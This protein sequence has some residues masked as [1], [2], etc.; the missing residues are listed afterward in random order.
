M[1]LGMSGGLPKGTQEEEH[2]DVNYYVEQERYFDDAYHATRS[3]APSPASRSVFSPPPPYSAVPGT[4]VDTP[5]PSSANEESSCSSDDF[6]SSD[7]DFNSWGHGPGPPPGSSS[8]TS[9]LLPHGHLLYTF[10]L[11]LD[12]GTNTPPASPQTPGTPH[13][14]P[15]PPANGPGTLSAASSPSP[16][17]PVMDPRVGG[18]PEDEVAPL[19]LGP[20]P[21]R[22]RSKSCRLLLLRT[23]IGI[24]STHNTNS[25]NSVP[26]AAPLS[27]KRRAVL[28]ERR[29]T[30]TVPIRPATVRTTWTCPLCRGNK[31]PITFARRVAYL[32]HLKIAHGMSW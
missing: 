22:L 21:G 8:S 10:A 3:Q 18:Q 12:I 5:H 1:A 20:S 23:S 28:T 31:P 15:H 30:A 26:A 25:K 7:D 32:R 19:T 2:H 11:R 14:T 29:H 27:T 24:H 9:V 16:T 17:V 6:D 4:F 13:P